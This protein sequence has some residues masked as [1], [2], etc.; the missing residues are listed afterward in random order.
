[1]QTEK[2]IAATG[3]IGMRNLKTFADTDQKKKYRLT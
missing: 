1:M 3:N 2:T